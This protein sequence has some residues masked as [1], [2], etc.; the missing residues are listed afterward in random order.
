MFKDVY[1]EVGLLEV[2]VT[3]LNRYHE[4]LKSQSSEES[5]SKGKYAYYPI[6]LCLARKIGKHCTPR[7]ESFFLSKLLSEG[8]ECN[9][10]V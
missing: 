8:F 10:V 2:F 7:V 6:T 3:C 9:K 5:Q 4:L 1:R